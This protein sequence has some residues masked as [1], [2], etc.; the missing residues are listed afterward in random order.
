[1]DA[2]GNS[3]FLQLPSAQNLKAQTGGTGCAASGYATFT[4]TYPTAV[5]TQTLA[6]VAS[7]SV[8]SGY[9]GYI[10][11]TPTVVQGGFSA[12]GFTYRASWAS[13]FAGSGFAVY[14][15]ALGN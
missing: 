6:V 10:T 15:V 7:L 3:S 4:I 1:M 11:G 13:A 9:E 8:A 14:W 12:S 2:L 5:P